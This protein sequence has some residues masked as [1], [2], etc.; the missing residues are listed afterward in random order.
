MSTLTAPR[1][2]ASVLP[3]Q[4][5][6][7]AA[8]L[9][10][11]PGTIVQ[12]DVGANV[13]LAGCRAGTALVALARQFPRSRFLGTEPSAEVREAARVSVQGGGVQNL[14]IASPETLQQARLQG[15][16]QYIIRQGGEPAAPMAA[17]PGLLREGGLVFDLARQLPPASA[18]H[19]AGLVILRSI[20][21]ADGCACII[22]G[23]WPMTG[24]GSAR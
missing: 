14:Q 7:A 15:I 4:L 9:P 10:A 23:N 16:F 12:L 13:L 1:R 6:L 21:L 2:A 5:D 24:P 11:V 17:L 8:V 19:D 3:S 20:R 18:Y 22:A